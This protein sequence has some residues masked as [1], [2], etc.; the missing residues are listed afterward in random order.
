MIDNLLVGIGVW[1]FSDGC[2]SLVLYRDKG[3]PFLRCHSIRV[4]RM[5]CALVV[6]G[7]GVYLGR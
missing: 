1:L 5:V 7:A 3:E 2:Y 6:I 4:M